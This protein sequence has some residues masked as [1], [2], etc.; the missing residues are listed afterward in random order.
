[1]MSL[2]VLV[3]LGGQAIG[4]PLTGWI[5]STWGPHVGMAVAGSVPALAALL[6][7]IHLARRHEL[8]I[9]VRLDGWAPR[10][11]IVRRIDGGLAG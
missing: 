6:I 1:V 7:G 11:A 10:V 4:G 8:R 9:K 5:V 3:L 2:Y